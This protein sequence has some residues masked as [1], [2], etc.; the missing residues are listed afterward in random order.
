MEVLV[1]VLC[2]LVVAVV[3]G[4]MAGHQQ[5]IRTSGYQPNKGPE[6]ENPQ[7]PKG[8]TGMTSSKHS[9]VPSNYSKD[10]TLYNELKQS[11]LERNQAMTEML[12]EQAKYWEG[13]NKSIEKGD[14]S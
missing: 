8:G 12:K 10:D 3:L 6:G 1:M 13:M 7:P 14:K 4:R 9:I 2:L 5:S 11:Q